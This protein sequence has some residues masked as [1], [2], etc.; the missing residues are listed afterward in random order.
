MFQATLIGSPSIDFVLA[1][2]GKGSVPIIVQGGAP[3]RTVNAAEELADYIEK[4]SGVRPELIKGLPEVVPG[5]AIWVGYQPVLDDLFPAVDFDFQHPEEILIAATADHLVIAGRDRWDP[6]NTVALRGHFTY[7]GNEIEHYQQE[8]GTVNAVYTFLQDHLGVRWFWPGEESVPASEEIAIAPFEYRYHPQIRQRQTV[9]RHLSL[10]NQGNRPSDRSDW[11]RFQRLQLDSLYVPVGG[12]GFGSWWNRFNETNRELFA[13]QPDGTRDL[14]SRPGTVKVCKSNPEVWDQWLADVVEQVEQHPHRT[15]F[16]AA[17]NDGGFSGFCICENCLAWDHP[18]GEMRRFAWRGLSQEYLALADRQVTLANQLGGML[19]E[20]F[21]DKDYRVVILAYGNSRPPPV[22]AVPADNVIIG[23]VGNFFL[24]PHAV[25]QGSPAGN[26]HRSQF[27]GWSEKTPHTVWRPNTGNVGGWREGGPA[28]LEGAA[29]AFK[30][31]AERGTIGINID[32][33]WNFWATQGPLYYLMAQL[34][35]NPGVDP[36][37]VMN[38]Y[39]QRGFGPAAEDVA[40]YWELMQA[41]NRRLRDSDDWN[42]AFDKE[43]LATAQALLQSAARKVAEGPAEYS[44]R[45]EYVANGLEYLQIQ[46]ENRILLAK[47]RGADKANPDTLKKA[48]DN[49]NRIVE[50]AEKHPD[51][52]NY[53]QIVRNPP[54]RLGAIYPGFSDD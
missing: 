2:P 24:N 48:R 3:V 21:P 37:A 15:V 14:Y 23:V 38:D 10:Y 25:D 22:A 36:A 52:F 40:A 54:G 7:G 26:T 8:Y 51:A 47:L 43:T 32:H 6:E 28:D 9:L 5:N 4:A 39:Y 18:E 12:H 13:L 1:S 50:M 33:P 34:A 17:A 35:W 31:V 16:S 45:L 46:S 53:S 20:R 27:E 11:A 41:A 42:D 44:R 30:F 49:W 19:K 29:D